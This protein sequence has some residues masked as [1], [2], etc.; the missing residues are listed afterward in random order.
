MDVA[1]QLRCGARAGSTRRC[2]SDGDPKV[3]INRQQG[4]WLASVAVATALAG[5]GYVI[6]AAAAPHGPSGGSVPGLAFGIAGTVL[7][8]VAGLLSFRKRVIARIGSAQLW[9][10]L[11]IWCSVLAVPLIFFHAGWRLGGP[12]TATLMVLFAIVI[13]SGVFG[14]IVQQVVPAMMTRRVP[15]ETIHSQI[16]H[17]GA[18]LA[19]DAY[20]IVASIAGP[21]EEAKEEQAA[22]AAEQALLQQRPG[23]WKQRQR[24]NPAEP[25][26]AGASVLRSFYLSEVR[27]YL[28]SRPRSRQGRPDFRAARHVAAEDWRAAIDRLA[29]LCDEWAQLGVQR[30]LHALLHGWLLLHVPLSFALFALIGVHIVNALRF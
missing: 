3:L 22:I 12:L 27:P 15:L 17:V 14:L 21:I 18:G 26:L 30:R 1:P 10:K 8:V 11:H 5:A 24:S 13:V 19:V 20:E 9:M 25:P 2:A 29:A 23:H 7:M 4:P 16:D 28:R 6:Y